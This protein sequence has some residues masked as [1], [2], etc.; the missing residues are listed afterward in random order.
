MTLLSLHEYLPLSDLAKIVAV[1]LVVALM[2]PAAV[3][4]GIVGLDRRHSGAVGAGNAMVAAGVAV[5]V[6][7]VGIGI[8]ALV[9]K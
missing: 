8:Y 9:H 2:A 4:V 5:I 3:S 1:A 7:L 6:A